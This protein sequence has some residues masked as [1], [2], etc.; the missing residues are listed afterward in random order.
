MADRQWTDEKFRDFSDFERLEF[1]AFSAA[2]NKKNEVTFVAKN[3]KSCNE[4]KSKLFGELGFE[5]KEMQSKE[6]ENLIDK[7]YYRKSSEAYS[8]ALDE[9][10]K[11]FRHIKNGNAEF[12][13]KENIIE[14]SI[15]SLNDAYKEGLKDSELMNN[16][17]GTPV[18]NKKINDL[19]D[20]WREQIEL[21]RKKLEVGNNEFNKSFF[22]DELTK[23]LGIIES[24]YQISSKSK[25]KKSDQFL[26]FSWKNFDYI[27]GPK[28]QLL[29]PY[30]L[31]W[32]SSETGQHFIKNMKDSMHESEVNNKMFVHLFKFIPIGINLLRWGDNE[33]FKCL[34]GDNAIGALPFDPAILERGLR[35]SFDHCKLGK[36]S[37]GNL[38]LILT[39]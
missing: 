32:F 34:Y 25:R 17:I 11:L 24:I 26:R 10:E 3:A 21:R 39:R 30:V 16:I 35:Y 29:S 19:F 2:F 36:H 20:Y 38:T 31:S 37:S 27:K 7:E 4:I 22:V 33:A 8:N 9:I 28:N 23:I 13:D 18:N 5:I 1:K 14:S 6:I 12:Y 15:R